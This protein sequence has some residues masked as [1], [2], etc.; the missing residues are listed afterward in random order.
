M[1]IYRFIRPVSVL[2]LI[3][4][5]AASCTKSVVVPISESERPHHGETYRVYLND[6]REIGTKDLHLEIDNSLTFSSLG[7]HY[8][9][10]MNEVARVERI[11]TDTDRTIIAL[12]VVAGL[13]ITAFYFLAKA[14]AESVP[15]TD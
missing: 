15:A 12:V 13:A 5:L 6:G 9:V 7:Q 14:V 10:Q 3:T 11:E 4:F 1:Q 8:H 2:V